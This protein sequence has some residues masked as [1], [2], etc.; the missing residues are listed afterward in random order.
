MVIYFLILVF[1]DGEWEDKSSG[2]KGSRH[3]PEATN[4]WFFRACCFDFQW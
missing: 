2:L 1:L 4:S 3:S